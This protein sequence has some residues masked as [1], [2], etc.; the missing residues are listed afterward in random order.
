M[1]QQ[2]IQLFLRLS[3]AGSFLSAVAD[4]LGYWPKDIS[5]WGNW[6]SFV[7]YTGQ[8][9][10][11]LPQPAINFAA[12]SATALEVVLGIFLIIGFKLKWTAL[13]SGILLLVFALSMVAALGIKAPLDYSVF[14]GAAASFALSQMKIKFLEVG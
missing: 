10:S 14:T 2:I 3:L 5:A 6:E 12:V 4:R 13:A 8:L 11:F 9:M 7:K 1:K